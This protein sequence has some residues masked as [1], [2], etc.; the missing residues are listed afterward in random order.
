MQTHEAHATKAKTFYWGITGNTTFDLD[1]SE[2]KNSMI[3]V[4]VF[5]KEGQR[6]SEDDE[7][8]LSDYF[9]VSRAE[10]FVALSF[11]ATQ[12]ALSVYPPR[13]CGM[14]LDIEDTLDM[15]IPVN[16]KSGESDVKIMM[17]LVFDKEHE[18]ELIKDYEFLE[19]ICKLPVLS[20]TQ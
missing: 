2:P 6:L 19:E 15:D 3:T 13:H 8:L 20:Q 14:F 17:N 18:G 16:Q 1:H 5:E 9:E 11:K 12:I 10:D 4:S 7:Q